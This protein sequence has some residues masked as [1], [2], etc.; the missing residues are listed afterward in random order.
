MGEHMRGQRVIVIGAGIGGLVAALLLAAR[1][2]AV[3]VV[4]RAAAPGGK[5]RRGRSGRRCAR[6]AVRP[7]S[8]CAGCSRRSSPPPARLSRDHVPLRHAETLARHAWGDSERLDLFADPARSADAIGVFAGAREADGYRALLRRG[9]AHLRNTAQTLHPRAAAEPRRP[10]RA[11]R[12]SAACRICCASRR[13]RRCGTRSASISAIRGCAS[14]SAATPPIAARRPFSRP[15]TL[16]LVAHVEQEGVWLVEGGMHRL[17]RAL[18]DLAQARGATFRYGREARRIVIECGRTLRASCSPTASGI[19]ADAVVVNADVARAARRTAR[20][21]TPRRAA[22]RCPAAQPLA[23][24]GDLA[25]RARTQGFPLLRHNVFFSRDYARRVR[26]DLRAPPP[27]GAADRLCLRPGSRRRGRADASAET[28]VLP[29]QRARRRRHRHLVAGGDRANAR[30]ADFRTLLGAAACRSNAQSDDV[31]DDAGGLRAAVPGDGRSA[32][33]PGVARL[34]GVVHA[35]GRA[36]ADAGP[37]SGGGQRASGAGRADGGD[38][39]TA[40]GAVPDRG[41]RFDAAVAAGRLSL[42][43]CRRAE[44][45]RPPT[46]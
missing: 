38:V 17:A 11:T 40:G 37:L 9:A 32:L 4:E 8:P 1:G 31:R 12:A 30:T 18:A 39:G 10:R 13:S 21:P 29:R 36:H 5:M 24:G 35:A 6:R 27:A 46:A 7:S 14:C 16:M 3:T 43:V 2:L 26:R 22:G 42:V 23:L 33:R 41:P 44:R 19:A 15:A 45:R 25:M 34:D 20:A 28:P